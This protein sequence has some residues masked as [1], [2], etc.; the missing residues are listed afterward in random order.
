M[1]VLR[2]ALAPFDR[3]AMHTPARQRYQDRSIVLLR[4]VGRRTG[5]IHERATAVARDG[6]RLVAVSDREIEGLVA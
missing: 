6:S 5:E 1:G 3:L 4:Y 2:R